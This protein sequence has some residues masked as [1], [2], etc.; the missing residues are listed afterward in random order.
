MSDFVKPML[1]CLPVLVTPAATMARAGAPGPSGRAAPPAA[2]GAVYELVLAEAVPEARDLRLLLRAE[3]SRFTA[4]VATG[5]NGRVTVD[6]AALTLKGDAISGSVKVAIGW[7]GFFPADGKTL[8]AEYRIEG[9]VSDGAVSGT[10]EGT[11]AGRAVA[12]RATG[13]LTPPSDLSGYW[14]MDIQMENGRGTGTLGPKSWGERVY[15]RLFLKDGR[16]V[17][18]LI[19]GWGKRVQINYFESAVT[20]N[21]LAFDGKTLRGRLAVRPTGDAPGTAGGR[22][23]VFTIDAA[24]VGTAVSGTF[25]KQV[26]GKACPGGPLHGTLEPLPARPLDRCVYYLELHKAVERTWQEADKAARLQLMAFAPRL[27]GR[28]GPGVAYAAAWNH[29]F[30]DLDPTGLK[31]AGDVLSGTLKVNTVQLRCIKQASK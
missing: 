16:W 3:G 6:A 9:K 27:G 28:F 17:Q 23:F 1:A 24:V 4:G 15:P 5:F 2:A 21:D 8:A 25:T 30:H 19:Y 20:A 31:V 22:D 7:D 13:A 10:Y 12:G 11:A 14:V 18:S 29:A 26:G